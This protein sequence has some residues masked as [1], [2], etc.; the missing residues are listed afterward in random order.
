MAKRAKRLS[1][2]EFA[3]ARNRLFSELAVLH[4]AWEQYNFLFLSG[5][6]RVKVLN[7]CAA[8]FFGMTQRL[9]MREMLLGIS[10]LTDKAAFG[11]FDNLT[12]E[13]LLRDPAL[14]GKT[15]LRALLGRRVR[16]AIR[17]AGPIRVHR[18][19]YIAH[20]DHAVAVGNPAALLPRFPLA[21]IRNSLDALEAV[22]NEHGR[23]VLGTD[24][25]F[26][27]NSLRAAEAL[28]RILEQSDR[29]TRWKASEE[30]NPSF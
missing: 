6:E 26:E 11:P 29:W 18:N 19:K 15:N 3:A 5:S 28:F 30:A 4:S 27:L 21:T 17:I 2:S 23:R 24:T 14:K 16:K 7:V 20:L 12:I 25:A 8:W 1:L 22:Y 10:R 13:G 9:L